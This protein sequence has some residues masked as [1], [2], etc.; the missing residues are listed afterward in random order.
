MTERNYFLDFNYLSG[1]ER[2]FGL[3]KLYQAG[4]LFCSPSTI[5]G[6]HLHGDCFELTIVTDGEGA[7]VTNDQRLSV[8]K[9]DIYFSFPGDFHD[10]VTSK[11]NPLK[12]DFF[13]FNTDD[14]ELKADLAEVMSTLSLGTRISATTESR[15]SFRRRLP[16]CRRRTS[17]PSACCPAYSCKPFTTSC[18]TSSGTPSRR[19]PTTFRPTSSSAT[20]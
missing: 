20:A 7:V 10:V 16:S 9:G 4:R 1:N 14:T 11:V 6:T 3:V 8:G 15:A 13:A 5:I 17:I 2:A 18:A 19:A 12:Y